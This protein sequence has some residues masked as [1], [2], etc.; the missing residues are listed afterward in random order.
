[1]EVER[2]VYEATISSKGQMV[3]PKPV[4]EK[5]HIR[6]GSKVKVIAGKDAIII[7]PRLEAPW[8]GLRGMMREQWRNKD[9]DALIEAAK[10]SLFKVGTHEQ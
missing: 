2:K 7:K 6:K 10:R 8:D 9:L 1:M 5:Y 4:R 3:I